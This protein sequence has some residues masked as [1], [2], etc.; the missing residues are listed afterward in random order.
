MDRSAFLARL[1]ASQA[2]P[3]PEPA[4]L[5]W[6]RPAQA[7]PADEFTARAKAAACGVT[8]ASG[9]EEA[10]SQ[11]VDILVQAG[12]SRAGLAGLGPE[13]EE[14]LRQAAALVGL[15]LVDAPDGHPDGVELGEPLAAGITRAELAV[16]ELGALVQVA[17][18]KGGRL[19]SLLPPLHLALLHVRDLLPTLGDLPGALTDAGRF[20]DGPPRGL[21]LIAGPSKTADIEAVMVPQVHGPG[22]VEIVV[23][24]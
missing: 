2:A 17:S 22:R 6:P 5:G 7:N 16:A 18:A 11:A 21:A 20:P 9:P 3:D 12:V 4:P 13:L 10:A 23:W 1:K 24:G 15:E 19:L 8:R 14:P